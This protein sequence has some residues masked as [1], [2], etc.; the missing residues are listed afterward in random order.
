MSINVGEVIAVRGTQVTLRIYEESSLE[1]IFHDGNMYKGVS[2]REYI[3]IKRGFC[4]IVCVV[5]GEYLDEKR[6]E[7]DDTKIQYIRKVEA[8]PIGYFEQGN[9]IDGIKLMPMIKDEAYLLNE[10]QVLK[11]FSQANDGKFKIGTMLKEELPVSLPWNKIFN[12]HIGIFGNTGSGKSNTL[13]KLYAE[14][15]TNFEDNLKGKSQFLLVDFN[16]EYT[17]NQLIKKVD[18]KKSFKLNTGKKAGDKLPLASTQ[19]WNTEI[20]ALLFQATAN[21]QT[22]FINRV[23]EGRKKYRH[24]A[25]SIKNYVKTTFDLCFVTTAHNNESLIHL[26]VIAKHLLHDPLI[27]KLNQVGWRN[28]K[29]VIDIGAYEDW[30][31]FGKQESFDAQ[32]APLIDGIDLTK[33]DEFDELIVRIN[34]QLLRDLLRGHIQ[35]EHIQPLLKRVES[36]VYDLRKIFTVQ[37][38][39]DAD[40]KL[41]NVISL[42]DCNQDVKK[43]VPLLLAKMF[44]QSHRDSVKA[45]PDKTLHFIIDEAH[46][47]LSHQSNR[48]RESWKDY[49][50]EMFEEIIKEG[51][52]FGIYLTLSSQRPADISPTIMSQL[53]NFFI[54]RLVNDR[55]LFLVDNTISTLDRMSK[56]LIPNLSKGACVVTGTAFD[57]PI[58]MQVEYIEN[59][60]SRPDSDDVDLGELWGLNKERKNE[61]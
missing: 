34:V 46:N 4:L 43:V 22:P 9:F 18:N 41:L 12:S 5:E 11:V 55:D 47:I 52:K 7:L 19:L 51:R 49:R 27:Q 37:D 35:F 29:F 17:G 2:I 25:N 32:I 33:I 26:K 14:L 16:G 30:V 6:F 31:W 23:I 40:F 59:K 61:D 21:T 24:L 57:L 45:P 13:T 28:D 56:S 44:Y 8:K 15:F 50:L 39:I 36:A 53:H 10:S 60:G 42:R 38:T 54:H 20:L 58:V 48:E 1:T 3:G